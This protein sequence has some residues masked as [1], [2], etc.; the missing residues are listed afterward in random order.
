MGRNAEAKH[1]VTQAVEQTNL[2]FFL[3][4][5]LLLLLLL[6]GVYTHYKLRYTPQLSIRYPYLT[7]LAASSSC[8]LHLSTMNKG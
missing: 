4:N 3:L 6:Q 5:F 2:C 1:K 8:M 7:L